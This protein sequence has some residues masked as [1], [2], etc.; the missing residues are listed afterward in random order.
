MPRT[1]PY[2]GQERVPAGHGGGPTALWQCSVLNSQVRR[3]WSFPAGRSW[4]QIPR[5]WR[6]PVGP[7]GDACPIHQELQ[8]H[9]Q[10][11]GRWVKQLP[12]SPQASGLLVAAG[13]ESGR[14]QAALKWSRSSLRIHAYRLNG[15]Q[16]TFRLSRHGTGRGV[17]QRAAAT[18]ATTMCGDQR[19]VEAKADAVG[20]SI[21]IHWKLSSL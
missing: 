4:W 14:V 2:G 8:P 21:L 19:A 9:L 18:A 16:C 10:P 3:I 20:H 15:C 5:G 1:W 12:V 13:E 7:Q 6:P 11:A 17:N